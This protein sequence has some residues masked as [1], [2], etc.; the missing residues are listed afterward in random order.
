MC[1]NF[2]NVGSRPTPPP[3]STRTCPPLPT[4]SPN[5][6]VLGCRVTCIAPHSLQ[7][8]SA[9][10]RA[11]IDVPT[12]PVSSPTHAFPS[13]AQFQ[14]RKK[15]DFLLPVMLVDFWPS[16]TSLPTLADPML[17]EREREGEGALYPED[18]QGK[19]NR[20][21]LGEAVAGRRLATGSQK[22]GP[23]RGWAGCNSRG[24]VEEFVDWGSRLRVHG[25][26]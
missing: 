26:F 23:R 4:D 11:A 9:P 15:C 14:H 18:W 13:G 21:V 12:N 16:S 19:P 10:R 3:V 22:H 25:K 24:G 17:G 1:T 2:L 6:L 8:C 7:M 20:P 5:Q